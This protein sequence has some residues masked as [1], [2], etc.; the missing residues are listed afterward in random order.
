M[1]EARSEWRDSARS[2]FLQKF[3][4]IHP[5]GVLPSVGASPFAIYAI[6]RGSNSSPLQSATAL[7]TEGGAMRNMRHWLGLTQ[8]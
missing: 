6:F 1:N 5:W 2:F 7:R 4:T 3:F 8:Q